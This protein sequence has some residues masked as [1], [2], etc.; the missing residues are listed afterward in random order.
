MDSST[1]QLLNALPGPVGW[2]PLEAPGVMTKSEYA[3]VVYL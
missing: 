1:Y 3:K 2:V